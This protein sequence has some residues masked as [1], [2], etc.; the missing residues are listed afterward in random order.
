VLYS[1]SERRYWVQ[2]IPHHSRPLVQVPRFF[3]R[4]Y[5]AAMLGNTLTILLG[6]LLAIFMAGTILWPW[7]MRRRP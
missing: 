2:A 3:M 5:N 1:L 4:C 6:V 7:L